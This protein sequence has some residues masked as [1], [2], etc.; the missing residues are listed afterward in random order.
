MTSLG[1][2]EIR[3]TPIGVISHFF[4]LLFVLFQRSLTCF[5][6]A[7]L[8]TIVQLGKS[9]FVTSKINSEYFDFKI[10]RKSSCQCYVASLKM[11]F[12]E[13]S[14][15]MKKFWHSEL[16]LCFTVTS[17]S[18]IE[19]LMRKKPITFKQGTPPRTC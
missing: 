19:P 17:H 13:G 16:L 12:Y 5:F 18:K 3:E 2:N 4:H 11:I 9:R 10:L 7:T 14:N 6:S 8:S 1:Q 15:H